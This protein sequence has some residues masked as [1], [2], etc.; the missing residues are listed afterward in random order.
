MSIQISIEMRIFFVFKVCSVKENFSFFMQVENYELSFHA[1]YKLQ[2]FFV[3]AV[4]FS[5]K[6][7]FKMLIKKL[8]LF[9]QYFC[10]YNSEV[11]CTLAYI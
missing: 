11:N 6:I 3:L 9:L 5:S 8:P 2:K 4:N 7:S 10:Y 1:R